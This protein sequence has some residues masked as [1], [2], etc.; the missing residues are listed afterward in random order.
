MPMVNGKEVFYD[1]KKQQEVQIDINKE[2]NIPADVK[3]EIDLQKFRKQFEKIDGEDASNLSIFFDD[4][5]VDGMRS[6]NDRR[7][8]YDVFRTMGDSELLNR[9][10]EIIAD[11]GSLQNEDGNVLKI[12]S[13]NEEIK[14]IGEELFIK[15]LD[16]NSELWNI[17]YNTAKFGDGFY[18]IVPNSFKD[19]K[20]IAQLKYLEPDRTERI[21]IDGKLAMFRYTVD[22]DERAK[23]NFKY[24]NFDFLNKEKDKKI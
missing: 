7:T 11:D 23:N 6:L 3:T 22:L 24:G 9:G 4:A 21:E 1:F 17:I 19:P 15:K 12:I 16:I 20:E 5:N 18:E 10:L 13:P 14:T 8:K 2:K